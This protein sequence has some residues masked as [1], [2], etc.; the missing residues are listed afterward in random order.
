MSL[1]IIIL[2]QNGLNYI[3]KLAISPIHKFV[4]SLFT[5][6]RHLVSLVLKI[7]IFYQY[8]KLLSKCSD[9]HV[10]SWCDI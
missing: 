9:M 2:T 8:A 5:K 1:I 6:F 10:L 3:F 7:M 4:L